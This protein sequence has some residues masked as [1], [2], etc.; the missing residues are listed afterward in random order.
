MKN[1][2]KTMLSGR[3]LVAAGLLI[4]AVALPGCTE[5]GGDAQKLTAEEGIDWE[6]IEAEGAEIAEGQKQGE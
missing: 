2:T 1:N 4:S 5:S 3:C 6:A